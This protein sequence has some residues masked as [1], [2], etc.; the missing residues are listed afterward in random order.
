MAELVPVEPFDIVVFGA[1]G[2][3]ALR[4]LIPALFHRWCDGQI[5]EDSR[6]IAAARDTLSDEDFRTL[7]ATH[8]MT[9]D[10]CAERQDNWTRFTQ[11]IHYSAL[12]VSRDGDD[13]LD[14]KAAL[15]PDE[16]KIRLYYLA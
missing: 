2:D 12:D 13:W 8:I 6:I 1:T 14:L 16:D 4:K 15:D 5:T 10:A 9:G 11:L 3:L 7:A